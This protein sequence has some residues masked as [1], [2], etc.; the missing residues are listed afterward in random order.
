MKIYIKDERPNF[1][2]LNLSGIIKFQQNFIQ[3]ND[4]AP[5]LLPYIMRS[6]PLD[7]P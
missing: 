6:M 4:N 1:R 7:L 3:L 5:I 2:F